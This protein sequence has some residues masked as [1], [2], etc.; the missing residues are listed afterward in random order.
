VLWPAVIFFWVQYIISFI[1]LL[2]LDLDLPEPVV[3]VETSDIIEV[4]SVNGPDKPA[5]IETEIDTIDVEPAKVRR[6]VSWME[7]IYLGIPNPNPFL[8][9]LTTAVNAAMLMMVLDLTFRRYLFYPVTDLSFH[10]PV[11][12]SPY[13]AN[14][15]IRSPSEEASPL[16]LFY[17]P[18]TQSLWER[19]P[20]TSEF[21]EA[22][23][24]TTIVSL[25]ELF[26]ST[27]YTYAVLP[28]GIDINAANQSLFGTFETFPAP[29]KRGRWSFGSS[30]CIMLGVPYNPLNDPL[31]VQGLEFLEKDM[32]DLKFFTF[33]GITI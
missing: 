7:T 19:G 16:R 28:L 12:T 14:I 22:L 33:L 1:L 23:D 29:G 13:S 31:R 17:K 30:S 25:N 10:R 20:I 4:I 24:F 15:F 6:S 3:N 32:P 2:Y 8:S 5:I 11:P 21:D 18:N 26:P 9:F 27:Q